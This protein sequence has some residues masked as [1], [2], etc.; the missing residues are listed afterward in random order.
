MSEYH[1]DIMAD[2]LDFVMSFF[3]QNFVAGVVT[4][5]EGDGI[6]LP[7]GDLDI[8]SYEYKIRLWA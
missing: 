1:H 4:V 2:G 7:L 8:P 5:E 6:G 3:T